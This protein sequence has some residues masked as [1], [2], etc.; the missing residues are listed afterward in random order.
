MNF[1]DSLTTTGFTGGSHVVVAACVSGFP[2]GHGIS[3]W[4]PP[5]IYLHIYTL[6][7]ENRITLRKPWHG[8]VEVLLN[9]CSQ[10]EVNYV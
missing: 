4:Q 3:V 1:D 10:E 9:E 7:K 5:H 8:H 6:M 2:L